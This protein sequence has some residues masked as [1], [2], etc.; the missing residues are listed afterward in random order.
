MTSQRSMLS[1]L[2]IVN[3]QN[4]P[5]Y[6]QDTIL[7]A[8][9]DASNKSLN[10]IT[11]S[12]CRPRRGKFISGPVR[13]PLI[14]AAMRSA[15]FARASL[16]AAA[17]SLSLLLEVSGGYVCEGVR[18]I[19]SSVPCRGLRPPPPPSLPPDRSMP[20]I[21]A[22]STFPADPIAVFM[23]TLAAE[24]RSPRQIGHTRERFGCRSSLCAQAPQ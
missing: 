18:P 6:A 17:L 14:V 9:T 22:S 4:S 16:A 13:G 12:K 2:S 15:A 23:S 19:A 7:A 20:P 11:I 8:I 1:N 21:E 10:Y 3:H 24:P 5:P